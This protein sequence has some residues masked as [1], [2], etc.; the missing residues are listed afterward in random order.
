MLFEQ[1]SRQEG[2]EFV[3]Q[4]RL[5]DLGV[6]MVRLTRRRG[7]K[8]FP[9]FEPGSNS[10]DR[11]ARY[12][13]QLK[14][15][16]FQQETIA[17]AACSVGLGSRQFPELFRKVTGQSWR[18]YVL[19]LRLK[20][21][22]ELLSETD[23]SVS[24]VAFEA[25]FEDLSNFHHCFKAAYGCAPLAYREQRRVRLPVRTTPVSEVARPGQPATG[26]RFRGMKRWSWTP[27]QYLEEIP[28]LA[29][30]KMN[31]LMNCYRSM[32]VSQPGESWRNVWWKPLSGERKEAF[33]RI[34]RTCRDH[35]ITLCFALHPQLASPRPLNPA[36]AEDVNLFLQHYVWAQS[37]GVKWSSICLD[38][39]GT[40]TRSTMAA[41][42]CT[43][44]RSADARRICA[45]SSRAT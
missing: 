37:Q 11:V 33:A 27:D 20:H 42:R 9:A 29:A 17:D 6:R 31:F 18:Q 44:A 5:L 16:F 41:R 7:R 43:L 14:S 40:T 3:L 22:A 45:K 8:D 10:T 26:F 36:R 19:G 13:L 4:S 39:S 15:Q 32:T 34:S 1:E 28:T 21:A 25:G 30:L 24:A 2:W 38:G 12:A 23:R 35:G